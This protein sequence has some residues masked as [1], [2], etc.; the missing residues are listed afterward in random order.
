MRDF[1]LDI[2]DVWRAC[3]YVSHEAR[4]AWKRYWILNNGVNPDDCIF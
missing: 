4:L 1:L 2:R 3:V